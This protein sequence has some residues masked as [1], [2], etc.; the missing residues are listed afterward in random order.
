MTDSPRARKAGGGD[1]LARRRP[2]QGAHQ[3]GDGI[4]LQELG[5]DG[6]AAQDAA[7]EGVQNTREREVRQRLRGLERERCQAGP[8][9]AIWPTHSCGNTAIKG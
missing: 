9:D 1:Q 2:A 8:K 5:R 6:G 4:V 7:V 3:H